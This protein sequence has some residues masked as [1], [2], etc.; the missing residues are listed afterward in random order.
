MGFHRL[1]Y[2]KK[3]YRHHAGAPP[4][5][6]E[7][8]SQNARDEKA[9]FTAAKK[10]KA[11]AALPSGVA[12]SGGDGGGGGSSSSSSMPV[13]GQKRQRSPV[14]SKALEAENASLRTENEKLKT[15]VAKYKRLSQAVG[16]RSAGSPAASPAGPSAGA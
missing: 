6:E 8:I 14:D 3:H 1:E 4:L 2:L 9:K 15:E 11:A 13:V 16:F 12:P 7:V 10:A 5:N